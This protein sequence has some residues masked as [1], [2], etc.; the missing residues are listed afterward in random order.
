MEQ[1][2]VYFPGSAGNS[3]LPSIETLQDEAKGA[4]LTKAIVRL[5]SKMCCLQ[6]EVMKCD[7]DRGTSHTQ[8]TSDLAVAL[9]L[10]PR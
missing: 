8:P 5:R 3:V 2:A 6:A 7:T 1:D 9:T 4:D 10:S